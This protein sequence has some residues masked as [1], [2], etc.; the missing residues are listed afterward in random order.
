MKK[1][2]VNI[3]SDIACPWCYVGE[4]ALKIGAEEFLNQNENIKI[5]TVFHPYIIDA[6]TDKN[7]EDYLAY[8]KRRWGSD[9]WTSELKEKGKQF[10]CT[11]GNWKFWPN[12]F[13]AHCLATE[14]KKIGKQ[15]EII[16]D[17]FKA[18]YEEGQNVSSEDVLNK[19]AE[20]YNIKNWNNE[21]NLKDV[22][23]SDKDAKNKRDIHS[24]PYFVFEDGTVINGSGSPD[25]FFIALNKNK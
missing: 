14:A 22:E 18:Q 25:K 1:I 23:E 7:G 17:I 16:E 12:T 5:E 10:G 24:V 11:F 2:T 15:S 13:L 21:A 4:Q 3:W 6:K 9:S 20:K 8:N 19:I